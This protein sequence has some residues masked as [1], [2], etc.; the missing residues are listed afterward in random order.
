MIRRKGKGD[1]MNERKEGQRENVKK[2]IGRNLFHACFA[3]SA[4]PRKTGGL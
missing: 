3:R 4:K 2:Q 1:G